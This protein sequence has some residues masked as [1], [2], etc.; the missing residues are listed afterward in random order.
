MIDRP[1]E[2]VAVAIA[3]SIAMATAMG[4]GRFVLTPI[5][6]PMI[7]ALG[8][9]AAQAGFIAS[10]NFL[11]YLIGAIAAAGAGFSHDRRRWLLVGLAASALTTGA[12]AIT[13]QLAV[14]MG[15]RFLGGLASAFVLVFASTMVLET[16]ARTQR[17][18]LSSWHFAGVGI[19]ITLSAVVVAL[20]AAGAGDWRA[21]WLWS[22]ALS[23]AGLAAVAWVVPKQVANA[24]SA[25]VTQDGGTGA[26]PG[27][28]PGLGALI[29]AYGLFGFGY[30]ITA[31]FISTMV[32]L[33]E[34]PEWLETAA[35][36]VVGLAAIPS[37][38]VW[39]AIA[40]RTGAMGAFAIACLVQ[41]VGVAVSVLL[42]GV[43]A[44]LAAAFLL[45]GTFMGLT[46][47][48]I[49]AARTASPG[50]PTRAIALMTAAFGVG[51]MIGPSI[52]GAMADRFG[53]FTAP[54]LAA[55]T[56]L[57]A[58]AV[59]A[60]TCGPGRGKVTPEA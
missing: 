41:G 40:A 55:A 19:G 45:G 28:G 29:A 7:D 57:V 47:L 18:A 34:G 1:S 42:G 24:V 22:G 49:A 35:W 39:S 25:G 14:L 20:V 3:G 53:G 26:T 38:A 23:L 4:V 31:T 8:L 15:L 33:G 43:L 44:I 21:Q 52:G 50:N 12:M 2:A 37:V 58:A 16:L 6:P 36:A 13:G 32:R 11:G 51:Q 17:S 27:A 30:V 48:G 5:L 10:A 60:Y 46:A 9:N 54:S 59:L 56:A